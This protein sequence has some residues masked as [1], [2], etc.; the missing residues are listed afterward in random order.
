MY[1]ADGAIDGLAE[2]DI[3]TD[4]DLARREIALGSCG[5]PRGSPEREKMSLA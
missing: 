2:V 4:G 1:L 5:A 3:A